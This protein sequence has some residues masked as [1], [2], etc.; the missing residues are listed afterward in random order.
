MLQSLSIINYGPILLTLHLATISLAIMFMISMPL[1]WWL[2]NTKS[3]LGRVVE[4]LTALPL[5]L[6]PS[7]LGFYLLVFLGK[8]SFIGETWTSMTGEPL[9]FTFSGLVIASCIYSLPFVVQPLQAGFEALDK[10]TIEASLSL[11]ASSLR[12]FLDVMLPNM[13]RSLVVASVLVFAHTVGEFG[14]V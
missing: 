10:R 12:T 6:P 7:V 4:T 8:G 2:A 14:V 5:V 13:R 9:V 11:G 1:A 3:R